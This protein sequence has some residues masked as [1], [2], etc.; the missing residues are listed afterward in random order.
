[1]ATVLLHSLSWVRAC[2][3]VFLPSLIMFFFFFCTYPH[4]IRLYTLKLDAP[5]LKLLYNAD[6]C[7][8]CCFFFFGNTMCCEV[9][10]ACASDFILTRKWPLSVNLFG[11]WFDFCQW[12]SSS[13][14][15]FVVCCLSFDCIKTHFRGERGRSVPALSLRMIQSQR[16]TLHV[17][18]L[19]R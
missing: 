15:F 11:K 5:C 10:L 3:A 6:E 8:W 18:H 7:C 2:F 9:R 16:H 14:A 13:P 4:S 17:L 12:H 19:W 1:M